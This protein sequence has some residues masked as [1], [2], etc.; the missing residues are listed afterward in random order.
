MKTTLFAA[1]FVVTLTGLAQAQ[2]GFGRDMR[3]RDR[4]RWYNSLEKVGTGNNLD[5]F[6]ARRLKAMGIEPQDKKYI[7]VYVRPLTEETEPREF[8][9]CQDAVD[10]QRGTWAFVKVDFDKENVH[11]KAWKVTT[12]PAII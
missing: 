11:Q 2:G 12:A 8:G 4:I 9:N 3:E 5:P 7:F 10:A 1:A 6:E